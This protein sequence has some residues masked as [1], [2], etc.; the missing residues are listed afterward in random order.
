MTAGVL[1]WAGISLAPAVD[2]VMSLSNVVTRAGL[3]IS[4]YALPT[5]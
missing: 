2:A 5:G 3:A 4:L 1:P